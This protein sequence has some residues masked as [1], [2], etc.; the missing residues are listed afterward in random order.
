MKKKEDPRHIKRKLA[1]QEI[2][3]F[4]FLPGQKKDSDLAKRTIE[5]IEKID[6]IVAK[7]A[8]LWPLPSMPPL[9]L[10]ILRLSVYELIFEKK[11]PLKVV[12][13]EA[14]EL[15]KEFGSESTSSFVNGVLGSIVDELEIKN[16]RGK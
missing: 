13:D 9:D 1:I 8:P 14:V 16:G 15:S 5:K 7:H 11:T 3:A 2:Y 6:P 12:I 4:S 10:A